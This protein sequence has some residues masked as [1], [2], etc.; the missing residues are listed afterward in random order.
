[1]SLSQTKR[2]G[3]HVGKTLHR[4]ETLR[5]LGSTADFHDGQTTDILLLS[6]ASGTWQLS[7]S[8]RVAAS[9]GSFLGVVNGVVELAPFD[10]ILKKG[11]F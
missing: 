11:L 9:D 7:L 2:Q 5:F 6:A 3:R 8:K 10:D 1:M 4:M